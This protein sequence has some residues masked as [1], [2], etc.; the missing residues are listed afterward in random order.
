MEFVFSGKKIRISD[1]HTWRPPWQRWP[2][3]R[4]NI[5]K[6]LQFRLNFAFVIS[7][8]T[9]LYAQFQPVPSTAI[10]GRLCA[11]SLLHLKWRPVSNVNSIKNLLSHAPLTHFPQK[12]LKRLK[13]YA[14]APE[15]CWRFSIF[16]DEQM[17]RNHRRN[18]SHHGLHRLGRNIVVLAFWHSTLC[19]NLETSE[20]NFRRYSQ[21]VRASHA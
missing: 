13:F 20:R 4:R 14:Y 18:S 6:M 7:S 17:S 3:V 5:V 11:M 21:L 10:R 15:T 8:L 12:Q 9:T 19:R 16:D 2:L 1:L